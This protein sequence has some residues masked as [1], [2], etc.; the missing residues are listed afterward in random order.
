MNS[1]AHIL[2]VDDDDLLRESIRA[3]LEQ[4]GFKVSVAATGN[5]ALAAA[6]RNFPDVVILD[7]GLTDSD[8]LDICR[9]LQRDHPA[10]RVIFLT[11]RS[12][13][14]DKVS[15]L[16]LGDDYMTKP[17]SIIELEARIGA[18]LRRHREPT[19]HLPAPVIEMGKIRLEPA[20][21]QVTLR[22]QPI[23]LTN[24][25]FDL[26][27]LLMSH[28]GEVFTANE[29]LSAIWGPEYIGAH[30]LVYVHV[31]WLRQKICDDPRH[32]KL[33]HTVRGVGYRFMPE[34]P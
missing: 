13:D 4:D 20:S 2:I 11:G 17:F 15:G 16:A 7:I 34:N 31:S 25:E 28:A 3:R 27:H 32:P 23:E 12:S 6:S 29:I 8:G 19:Q 10:L 26:L 9:A 14:I 5:L 33:L 30:E 18:V 21:H 1:K 22:G 24:K